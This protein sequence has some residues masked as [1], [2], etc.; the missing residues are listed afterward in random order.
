MHNHEISLSS[1]F[2]V[3]KRQ[4]K[5][6]FIMVGGSFILAGLYCAITPNV[7]RGEQDYR[8]QSSVTPKDLIEL[9]GRLDRDKFE[10][11][12]SNARSIRK[13][14]I[15]P[16]RDAKDKF[17]ISIEAEDLPSLPGAFPEII[18]YLGKMPIMV[19]SLKES[20][21]QYE[22]LTAHVKKID[23]LIKDLEGSEKRVFV[24]NPIDLYLKYQ[25]I[26]LQ[27]NRLEKIYNSREIIEALNPVSVSKTPVAPRKLFVF[28]LAGA[29]GLF[30]A[31][32][33]SFYLQYRANRN[34][35]VR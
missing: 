9:L 21:K 2:A 20:D 33:L 12:F 25:D 26:V 30:L 8:I 23:K 18:E 31:I 6:I 17:K 14:T 35:S 10:L 24:A 28:S 32:F 22:A 13:V 15:L 11:I 34:Q 5:F 3:L 16:Y 1:F 27:K 29:I 7:Y 19:Q 4:L